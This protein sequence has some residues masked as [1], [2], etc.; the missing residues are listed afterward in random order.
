MPH[1]RIAVVTGGSRGIG[2]QVCR[3][4]ARRGTYVIVH[5]PAPDEAHAAVAG[6]IRDGADPGLLRAASADFRRLDDVFSLAGHLERRH[7]RI[8]LLVNNA[9]TLV[10]AGLTGD[11]I[12]ANLQINYVAPYALTRL[13][14]PALNTAAGRIVTLADAVHRDGRLDL[15]EPGR[16]A[17][18]PVEAYAGAQLALVLFTRM[19]AR[20]AERRVTAV[21]VHPGIVDTGSFTAVHG[22]GGLPVADGAAHVLRAAD[23]DTDVVDGGYYEGIL[24]ADP[25]PQ[26]RD[27]TAARRLWSATARLLGWDYTA[28]RIPPVRAG[29]SAA[30]TSVIPAST[31]RINVFP[32]V[33]DGEHRQDMNSF[34]VSSGW[35][36]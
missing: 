15:D 10:P 7:G 8:D 11:G 19:L 18:R 23:P 12:D 9:G 27:D 20:T 33:T 2:R 3:E 14:A 35:V 30:S 29:V 6:L 28:A 16:G 21:A 17:G 25:A 22:A 13:L 26:A 24:A 4:L 32:R 1:P 5:A 36:R 34:S 31:A